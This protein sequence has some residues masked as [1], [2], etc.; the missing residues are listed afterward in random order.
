MATFLHRALTAP[1][2]AR[3]TAVDIG[4]RHACAIRVDK[5]VVCWGANDQGQATAPDGQFTAVTAGNRHTCGLRTDNTITCWGVNVFS[6]RRETPDGRFS[7]IAAGNAH[8][9]ALRTDNTAVCWGLNYDGQ[10]DAPDG[11]FSAITAGNRHTCALRTDNTITCW[12]DNEHGQSDP[13][14][15]HFSAVTAGHSHTCGLRTDNTITCW[16]DNEHEQTDSPIGHFSAV[17]TGGSH[18]CALSTDNT[19]ACWGANDLG[20]AVAPEGQFD[21]V[22]TADGGASCGLRTDG[23]IA[24]WGVGYFHRFLAVRAQP[25]GRFE[26]I[27]GGEGRYCGLRTDNTIACWGVN[28]LGESEPP[29]RQYSQVAFA[30][31]HSCGLRTDNTIACWGNNYQGT[32]EP[33]DGH[34]SAVAAGATHTCGLRT[35]GTVA[36]WGSNYHGTSDPPDGQFST[37]VAGGGHTCGLRTDNTAVCWGNNAHG[38]TDTPS[39]QFSAITAIRHRSCGLRTDNTAVCWGYNGFGESDAPDDQFSAI[40][41]GTSHSCGLRID[42]TVVCWGAQY[43]DSPTPT[44]RFSTIVAGG[45]H[46]CGLRTDGTITCWGSERSAPDGRFTALAIGGGNTCAIR[47]DGTVACWGYSV[48][49][50]PT[51]VDAVP[52]AYWPDPGSCRPYGAFPRHAS[53][54]TVGKVRVAVLFV[55]FPD[56]P[57]DYSTHDETG[58]NLDFAEQYLEASSYGK[59]DLEFVPLHR[60]LQAEHSFRHYEGPTATGAI[61]VHAQDEAVRLADP[62]FDFTGIHIVLVVHPSAYGSRGW[63]DG[64]LRNRT[65]EGRIGTVS[66]VNSDLG[67]RR[68]PRAPF[69]WGRVAA[70]ELAHN[71]GLP[72]LYPYP[73]YVEGELSG[74]RTQLLSEQ[75]GRW[76]GSGFGLMGLAVS[77]SIQEYQPNGAEAEMLA[78]NRF[79]LGWLDADQVRCVTESDATV[80]LDSIADPRDGMAMAV[81]PYAS[82]GVIVV[83]SRRAIRSDESAA[84]AQQELILEDGTTMTYG[85]V[86]SAARDEGVLVYSVNSSHGNGSLPIRGAGQTERGFAGE[87]PFLKEGES[88][89]VRGYRITL[90]SEDSATHTVNIT[91]ADPSN[92]NVTTRISSV[93]PPVV[94]GSFDV[95]ITFSRPVSG[96]EPDDFLVMEHEEYE[97][98][99]A[100]GTVSH[101]S[102]SGTDYTATIVPDSIKVGT[103]FVRNLVV[104]IQPGAVSSLSGRPNTMPKPLVRQFINPGPMVTIDSD[105]PLTVRGKFNVTITFTGPVTGFQQDDI[106]VVNGSVSS[107]SGSGSRYTATIVPDNFG[108]II[109]VTV[110]VPAGAAFDHDGNPSWAAEPLERESESTGRPTVTIGSSASLGVDGRFDVT[111]T[112]S[113]PVT[114]FMLDDIIVAGGTVTS[115]TGSGATYTASVLPGFERPF[116]QILVREHA[117][118]D[119]LQR[120][121]TRSEVF[122]RVL[123]DHPVDLCPT[124]DQ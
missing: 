85:D 40:T 92:T 64:N 108:N 86:A 48:R 12:G 56:A 71:F 19:V 15:G 32:S 44:G 28:A 51:A 4:D 96:L 65:D 60:W 37:I 54:P 63:G 9:C 34:F 45:N 72:D 13:P 3:F 36:C 31:Y 8:T 62:H 29:N 101:I 116:V 2:T 50:P 70:H 106:A 123:T 38:Q 103:R 102:G 61:Q 114:G 43:A 83:E 94:Q 104:S 46:T 14:N 52:R 80:T 26:A 122:C 100:F 30:A 82:S 33:P 59:L 57:A 117:A 49:P 39:G 78:W 99:V 22:A 25:D 17:A 89:T 11:Q 79:L 87:S 95:A 21:A 23:T 90:V 6:V 18:A 109:E 93:A 1:P 84:Y 24:C 58:S 81:I 121:S 67:T 111:I 16:G 5:T 88:I 119:E 77:T 69:N 76:D 97:G 42:T 55:D 91:R 20:Q 110:S 107:L 73:Q 118:N 112:F 124:G 41:L 7:T 113:T 120:P 74:L 115:L 98:L 53:A 27:E 10:S 66:A 47:T 105:A 35:D 75:L 68:S